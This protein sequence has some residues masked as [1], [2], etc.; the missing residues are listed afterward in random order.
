MS[1]WRFQHLGMVKKVIGMR[2]GTGGSSGTGYL[3]GAMD[4]HFVFFEIAE[5]N[6]YL[7]DTTRNPKLPEALT[8]KLCFHI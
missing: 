5:L 8:R 7:M 2:A 1:A 4:K 6:S 3:K